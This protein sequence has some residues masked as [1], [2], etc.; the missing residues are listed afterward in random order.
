MKTDRMIRINELLKREIAD[1]LYHVVHEGTVDLSTVTVTHVIA[2][3]NLRHARVLVSIRAPEADRPAVLGRI[4][5]HRNTIQQAINR[6]LKLKFTPHLHFELDSSLESGD[7]VLHLL[8]Q[9]DPIPAD[10]P[11]RTTDTPPA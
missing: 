6:N 10:E 9:L 11:D 7:R 5:R 8:D 2:S 3:N 1:Q 4:A